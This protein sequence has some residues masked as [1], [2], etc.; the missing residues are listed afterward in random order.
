MRGK[1]AANKKERSKTSDITETERWGLRERERARERDK[2]IEKSLVKW[3]YEI[4]LGQL[5]SHI[6]A[7]FNCFQTPHNVQFS[8]CDERIFGRE[9]KI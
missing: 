5:F 2:K 4:L 6:M 1:K 9:E 3:L 8:F 7:S